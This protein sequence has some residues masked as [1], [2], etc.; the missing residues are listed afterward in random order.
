[1]KNIVKILVSW[2]LSLLVTS[3]AQAIYDPLS[4]PN[5]RYGVHI[6]EPS[7][8]GRA[9]QLVNSSGG[10][11]G[12]VTIPLRS[13]DRDPVKWRQFFISAGQLK[14]TPIIRLATYPYGGTWARPTAYDLVD[15]ANF[16]ADMPW[17][18][19]NRYV[20]LFNEPNHAAEWGGSVDPNSYASLLVTAKSVF[21]ARS[22]DFFLLTAGLDMSAPDNRTSTDALRFWREVTRLQPDWPKYIDGYAFHAYPNP[23]FSA[24]PLSPGRYGLKSY[25][26]EQKLLP[27]KPIFITETGQIGQSRFFTTAFTSVWTDANLVAVTPFVLFAGTGDF[28]RFSLLG[29]DRLPTAAYL[30]LEQLPKTAGS[31]HLG[32]I[33]LPTPIPQTTRF[34]LALPATVP[35]FERIRELFAD[36]TE[37]SLTIGS[38]QLT[39][40]IADTD[41]SRAR[42]LSGRESL[43]P[44]HGMLFIF[45]SSHRPS[46]WMYDM[47]FALDFVW[48]NHG[49]VVGLTENVPPPSETSGRPTV[50]Q[51]DLYA[52]W[53]LEVPAGF[54]NRHGIK[55]GDAVVKSS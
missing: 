11:W 33:I 9:A 17:P 3:P 41:L 14:V 48:I 7:E 47:R 34:S 49:R 27:P 24:T 20:I 13:D 2:S 16:L 54:I 37:P 39:I 52:D 42:G 15:F 25:S 8:I 36:K 5:N 46:F 38:T 21:S 29:I 55:E 10:Q 45:P 44:N 50:I 4:V 1:M 19:K 26:Y 32:T 35:L 51:P 12:Y 23:G 31:P 6:L 22:P 43:P 53:V 30:D 18:T 28:V 40:E